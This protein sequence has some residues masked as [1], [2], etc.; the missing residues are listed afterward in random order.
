MLEA[1]YRKYDMEL[2]DNIPEEPKHA[3]SEVDPFPEDESQYRL[4]RFDLWP[5]T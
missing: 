1:S 3:R 5:V 4:N 2:F